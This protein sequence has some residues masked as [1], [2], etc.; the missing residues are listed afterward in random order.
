MFYCSFGIFLSSTATLYIYRKA[1]KQLNE[2]FDRI[3]KF[4]ITKNKPIFVTLMKHLHL[5]MASL[6]QFTQETSYE[7][8]IECFNPSDFSCIIQ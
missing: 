7:I 5:K 4:E 3:K 6:S 8:R 2:K 1:K